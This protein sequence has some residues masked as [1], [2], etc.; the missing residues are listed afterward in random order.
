MR[1]PGASESRTKT[2]NMGQKPK[3]CGKVKEHHKGTS[4]GLQIPI[5]AFISMAEQRGGSTQVRSFP[6]QR[7]LDG[8]PWECLSTQLRGWE[9]EKKII[10]VLPLPQLPQ[11][12]AGTPQAAS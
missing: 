2:T 10:L 9:E 4:Q 11:P 5:P 8:S 3:E 7:Q 1:F 12:G 6:R